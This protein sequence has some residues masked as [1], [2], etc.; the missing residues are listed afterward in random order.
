LNITAED[1]VIVGLIAV[2]VFLVWERFH[3]RHRISTVYDSLIGLTRGL[4]PRFEL[5]THDQLRRLFSLDAILDDME[6]KVA[7]LK[8][9]DE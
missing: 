1:V 8:E 6:E 5:R 9:Q 7:L 4:D 3:Y 2:V